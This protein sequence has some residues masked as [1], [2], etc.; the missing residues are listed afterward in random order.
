MPAVTRVFE[1][2]TLALAVEKRGQSLHHVQ[3]VGCLLIRGAL[4]DF[5]IRVADAAGR[6]VEAA[7]GAV[8]SPGIVDRDN[9]TVLVEQRDMG[10]QR[11][12]DGAVDFRESALSALD[13]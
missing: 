12:Q 1:R 10:G 5:Y 8:A 13:F 3:H 4:A 9:E 2:K 6:V 11:P 7:G